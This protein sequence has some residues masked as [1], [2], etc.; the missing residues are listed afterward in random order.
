MITNSDEIEVQNL[1]YTDLIKVGQAKIQFARMG[2]G[3]ESRTSYFHMRESFYKL[4]KSKRIFEFELLKLEVG[5]PFNDVW[6][7]FNEGCLDP[8]SKKLKE[9]CGIN[10]KIVELNLQ[11]VTDVNFVERIDRG[12]RNTTVNYN[13]RALA[14][15]ACCRIPKVVLLTAP[16]VT[17]YMSIHLANTIKE[18]EVIKLIDSDDESVANLL[19]VCGDA[20][21][22]DLIGLVDSNDGLSDMTDM[23]N[24]DDEFSDD[25]SLSYEKVECMSKGLWSAGKETAQKTSPTSTYVRFSKTPLGL[26]GKQVKMCIK[27]TEY[28]YQK[29]MDTIIVKGLES[30]I[31]IYPWVSRKF[32]SVVQAVMT[33]RSLHLKRMSSLFE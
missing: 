27:A 23:V 17:Q 26:S 14:D 8:E 16:S 13:E 9:D 18:K 6:Q 20:S 2:Y 29:Y 25:K 33:W 30:R 11:K 19:E 1:G 3:S 28:W 31:E 21:I 4:P 7:I 12:T 10:W 32:D 22:V 15:R 5:H 24:S